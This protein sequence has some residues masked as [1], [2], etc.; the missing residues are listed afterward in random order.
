MSHPSTEWQETSLW[1]PRGHSDLVLADSLQDCGTQPVEE[2]LV[3]PPAEPQPKGSSVGSLSA[4]LVC[5]LR[6]LPQPDTCPATRL[7]ES[8]LPGPHLAHTN[9][10]MFASHQKRI[11][12][13]D[14]I[15]QGFFFVSSLVES[16]FYSPLSFPG[17]TSPKQLCSV[18]CKFTNNAERLSL[19]HSQQVNEDRGW[20]M[21][22]WG[23]WLPDLTKTCNVIWC[24]F[25]YL[26]NLTFQI[27]NLHLI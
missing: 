26:I 20:E 9:L 16:L 14:W 10:L 17:K 25:L 3:L 5:K 8:R 13:F 4:R 2:A 12:E 11:P 1:Y 23:A 18:T 7:W 21:G 19:I 24:N 6:V 27:F 15:F 22:G